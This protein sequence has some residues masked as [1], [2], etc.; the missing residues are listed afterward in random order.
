MIERETERD[1]YKKN[2]KT[3]KTQTQYG[4]GYLSQKPSGKA[5]S[6]AFSGKQI[7]LD[8]NKH[9]TGGHSR[10]TTPYNASVSLSPS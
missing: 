2:P 7:L 5:L 1:T 3:I 6:L 9:P 4:K 10:G 8:P